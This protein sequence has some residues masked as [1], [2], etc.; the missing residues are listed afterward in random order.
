[1]N[2]Y[3][4]Q[5]WAELSDRLALGE[6]L[7]TAESRFELDHRSACS[8]CAGE[9]EV[10]AGLSGCLLDER[11]SSPDLTGDVLPG[12]GSNEATGRG[13]SRKST[14]IWM[15][16][17]AAVAAAS[18]AAGVSLPFGPSSDEAQE[19]QTRAGAEEAS[20][21]VDLL[22]VVGDVNVGGTPASAGATLGPRDRLATKE[23]KACVAYSNGTSACITGESEISLVGESSQDRKLHLSRGQVVCNLD[24]QPEG[25][26]FS[27]ETTRGTVVAKGT[28]FAVAYLASSEV[29]VR[30]H[31]GVVEVQSRSGQ[32]REL[33]AP[34]TLILGEH[35]RQG[36]READEWKRDE[37]MLAVTHLWADGAV[38]PLDVDPETE[39]ARISLGGVDLGQGPLSM[40]VAR[41][42]YE[43]LV[44]AE[45]YETHRETLLIK[46]AGRVTRSPTLTALTN[47]GQSPASNARPTTPADL[48][49]R[50]QKQR[51]AGRFGEAAATY[52]TLVEAHPGSGEAR[53]AWLSLGELQLS[54]LG[55][56][57]QAL[58]SFERYLAR[59]G[60]LTQEARYGK[61]RALRKLGRSSEAREEAG[62]F[63]A[64]Y[65]GTAQAV[66]LQQWLSAP[67]AAN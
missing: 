29:E 59:K 38:A 6:T 46:G 58:T 37:T 47:E 19:A 64:A 7:T 54:Q 53:A 62:K 4:C 49:A 26:V 50:A 63:V 44:K 61:I 24:R 66:S 5:R 33:H 9:A 1:M 25:T 12:R 15:I 30:L 39:Q 8:S 60:A 34:A 42:Q 67:P 10:W 65:P 56:P 40:L 52:Q 48:L 45:G 16:A 36:S 22:L 31:R 14:R 57:A 20:A 32:T 28:A 27:V 51:Q 11:P 35:M 13:L 2:A 21:P 17:A 43:L 41:G 55:A 23:G 18:V 3:D